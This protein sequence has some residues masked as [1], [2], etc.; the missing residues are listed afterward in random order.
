MIGTL[1]RPGTRLMR[2]LRLPAKLA[3]MGGALLLPLVVLMVHLFSSA[4]HEYSILSNEQNG[5]QL[6]RG[7]LELT[8]ALI[9]HRGLTHRALSGEEGI[10]AALQTSRARL[11]ASV[12]ALDAQIATRP[13]YQLADHWHGLRARIDTLLTDKSPRARAAALAFHGEQIEQ[14]RRLMLL[15]AE[16]SGLLLDPTAQSYFLVDLMVNPMI[17]WVDRMAQVS[18]VGGG[19]LTRGDATRL[20]KRDLLATAGSTQRQL[21]AIQSRIAS[22]LR[23]GVTLPSSWDTA[24]RGTEQF[25]G[26]VEQVFGAEALVGE[27][28]PYLRSGSEAGASAVRFGQDALDLLDDQLN[29]RLA[30]LRNRVIVQAAVAA[31]GVTVIAYLLLVFHYSFLGSLR[32][33]TASMDAMAAGDL[34]QPILIEG[35]DELSRVG[36]QLEAMAATWS[37]L[38]AE[39]R[40]S[41][42]RV[43]EAGQAVADQGQ[44]LSQR[45]ERQ[46]GSLRDSVG[47]VEQLGAAVASTAQATASLDDITT[48]LRQHAELGTQAMRETVA[49]IGALQD[50]T[51]RV[52]EINGVIDEIAFQTNLLALNAAVEAA[53]AGEAGKGFAVVSAEVRQLAQRCGEAAAEIRDLIGRTIEQTDVSA[54]RVHDVSIALDS[55]VH[56]ISDVADRLRGIAGSSAQQSAGLSEVSRGVQGLDEIT[57]QNADMVNASARSSQALVFQAAALGESVASIRLRYGSADEALA[58]VRCGLARVAEIGWEQASRELSDP[59]GEFHDRDMAVYVLDLTGKVLAY[60]ARPQWVGKMVHDLP[61]VSST[62]ADRFMDAVLAACG[63]GE[64]WAE[65]DWFNV[66][67][68]EPAR[69]TAYVAR[70]GDDALIGCGVFRTGERASLV[71]PSR[72]VASGAGDSA[73]GGT[74]D[75][76][77]LAHA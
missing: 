2:S 41:A 61:G 18:A 32:R 63:Q 70:L 45:T 34:S 25:V 75:R 10:Q 65:Y 30:T 67:T 8:T 59:Q 3:L 28:E 1:L 6:V 11:A 36:A 56:G 46:A 53:H 69:K 22:L 19:L 17:P 24:R 68:G 66:D 71:R 58:L 20:E 64:G 15:A 37:R 31:L 52:S 4:H 29:N 21:E 40:S 35:S 33:V 74:A 55:V 12:K 48:T 51:R 44:S 73:D 42:V 16:F 72:P 38:V 26:Q 50:T 77:A 76:D 5:A 14:A 27:P 43:G 49:S 23:A 60:S 13:G 62:M 7:T 54:I 47:T 39:I 57:R 9:D